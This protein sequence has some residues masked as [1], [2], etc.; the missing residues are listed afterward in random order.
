MRVDAHKKL[1]NHATAYNFKT[2]Q[3]IK[4]LY[5]RLTV[6]TTTAE[7]SCAWGPPTTE[8]EAPGE[9]LYK[10]EASGVDPLAKSTNFD[11]HGQKREKID[12]K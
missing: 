7:Q 6:E 4:H 5:K 12:A 8:L 1:C 10:I 3:P 9:P 11:K 2:P